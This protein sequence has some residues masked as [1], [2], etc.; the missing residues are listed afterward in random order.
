MRSSS[1]LLL[2]RASDTGTSRQ[3]LQEPIA[4]EIVGLT[5]LLNLEIVGL[6][7]L[8][9]LEIVGLT[10]LLNL[11]SHASTSRGCLQDV[12]EQVSSHALLYRRVR[13]AQPCLQVLLLTLL[14][15]FYYSLYYP[16]LSPRPRSSTLSTGE[17]NK[18]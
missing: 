13:G 7:L 6:T 12:D 1:I 16:S 14:P 5:L 9:N 11:V 2:N 17:S 18:P 4:L 3:C 10:L 8:L 15:F